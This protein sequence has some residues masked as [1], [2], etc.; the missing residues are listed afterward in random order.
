MARIL[1]VANKKDFL[2]FIE[3]IQEGKR[4]NIKAVEKG[5]A[6]TK[7]VY[8]FCFSLNKYDFVDKTTCGDDKL[9]KK[10]EDLLDKIENNYLYMNILPELEFYCEKRSM[11]HHNVYLTSLT[12]ETVLEKLQFP[13]LI[14]QDSKFYE[15]R[16]GDVSQLNFKIVSTVDFL[17]NDLI[18][19]VNDLIFDDHHDL[20]TRNDGYFYEDY[21][22][23]EPNLDLPEHLQGPL[24]VPQ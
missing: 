13:C 5:D 22:N 23:D 19:S 15:I 18:T 6:E 2:Q 11:Y 17:Q 4:H 21:E 12:L 10:D 14:F 1:K 7:E 9:S 24:W 16:N 20:N 3:K 8:T